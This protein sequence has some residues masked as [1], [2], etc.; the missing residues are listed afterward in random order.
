MDKKLLLCR[1]KGAQLL[2]K[3]LINDIVCGYYSEVDA[4]RHYG[5]S[6]NLLIAWTGQTGFV[7]WI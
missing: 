6:T 7:I 2:R 4:V 1:G 5:I 3:Q